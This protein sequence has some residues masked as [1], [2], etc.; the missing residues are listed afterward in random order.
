MTHNKTWQASRTESKI[1]F[2][3]MQE[4]LQAKRQ[5]DGKETKPHHYH[6]PPTMRFKGVLMLANG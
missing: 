1:G 6:K 5:A 2:Q 3:V 4:I